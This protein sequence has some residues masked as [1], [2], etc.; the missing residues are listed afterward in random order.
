MM[1][2]GV[3]PLTA[4]VALTSVV[5]VAVIVITLW[6]KGVQEDIQRKQGG[7]ALAQLSCT[8][9]DF[10][11][12]GTTLDSV[13]VENRGP[14]LAGV[15]LVVKGDGNVQSQLFSQPIERGGSRSFPFVGIPG[16]G[17]VEEVA[18]IATV[19]EGVNR[20]CVDQKKEV[21]L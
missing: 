19:G 6:G 14:D 8:G 11:I 3:T 18:V 13:T 1:S 9:I 17:D 16:V 20:P 12:T 7:I 2:R 10:D 21:T 4:T 5:V 15:V